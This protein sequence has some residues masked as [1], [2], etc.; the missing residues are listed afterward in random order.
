MPWI[1]FTD[2]EQLDLIDAAAEMAAAALAARSR[3]VDEDNV[4]SRSVDMSRIKLATFRQ[5]VQTA[6]LVDFSEF[7]D[8]DRQKFFQMVDMLREVKD[9]KAADAIWQGLR[10][11]VLRPGKREPF[12]A[13]KSPWLDE[14]LSFPKV[15][16]C[17]ESSA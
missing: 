7:S 12:K 6:P 14:D 15:A 3:R 5:Q 4:I 11:I 16:G 10:A 8:A 9:G 1:I 13:G 17:A 2:Q